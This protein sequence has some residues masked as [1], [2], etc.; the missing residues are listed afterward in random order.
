[1]LDWHV[2]PSTGLFLS[3]SLWHWAERVQGT[4]SHPSFSCY[5]QKT[6][7][8]ISE[9]GAGLQREQGV[10]RVVKSS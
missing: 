9:V 10:G 8:W 2:W 6:M 7:G 4:P 3:P 5:L 1:M